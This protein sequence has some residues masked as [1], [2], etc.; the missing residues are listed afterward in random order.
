[1]KLFSKFFYF[2]TDPFK[3]ICSSSC[4]STFPFMSSTQPTFKNS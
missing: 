3:I 4:Q 1:M 2:D